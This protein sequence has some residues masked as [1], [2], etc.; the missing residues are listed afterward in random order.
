MR[1]VVARE[2]RPGLGGVGP[3]LETLAPATGRFPESDGTEEGRRQSPAHS[4][5]Q[6]P[7]R[8]NHLCSFGIKVRDEVL[9]M[10]T[11]QNSI[12]WRAW[13]IPLQDAARAQ[14]GG[15]ARHCWTWRA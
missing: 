8:A 7:P 11:G 10:A 9:D 5:F 3:L 4:A 14:E 2:H 6:V 15:R 12:A 1:L 13:T